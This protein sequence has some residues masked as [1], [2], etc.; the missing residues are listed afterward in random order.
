MA[1][2]A[3]EPVF[4]LGNTLF[5]NLMAT[6]DAHGNA[7]SLSAMVINEPLAWC[8]TGNVELVGGPNNESKPVK[9]KGFFGLVPSQKTLVLFD[10]VRRM[11]LQLDSTTMQYRNLDKVPTGET[12][13]FSDPANG[14]V[15]LWDARRQILSEKKSGP[16][17]RARRIKFRNEYQVL[18]QGS[19]FAAIR[20]DVANNGF[21]IH[22]IPEWTGVTQERE[23]NFKLPE[24]YRVSQATVIPLFDRKLA[25]VTGRTDDVRRRWQKVF[26]VDYRDGKILREFKTDGVDYFGE[27]GISP[28]TKNILLVEMNGTN[29]TASKTRIFNLSKETERQLEIIAP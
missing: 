12:P 10:P 23:F 16:S 3:V 5:A 7:S 21:R 28:D 22:E 6:L 4:G 8:A 2:H 13:I 24:G 15:V 25:L 9:R 1:G 11:L 29:S 26:L 27:C 20:T 18:Q 14:S 19:R 17:K